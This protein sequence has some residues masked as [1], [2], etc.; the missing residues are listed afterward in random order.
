[1]KAILFFVFTLSL[2]CSTE[3]LVQRTTRLYPIADSILRN[4]YPNN[5]YGTVVTSPV[6]Q[7]WGADDNN[8]T[9]DF[10]ELV[11]MFNINSTF[12]PGAIIT[13]KIYYPQLNRVQA[14]V[15]SEVVF[16]A[17]EIYTNWTET[18]VTYNNRP[19]LRQSITTSH[20]DGDIDN[21]II[22]SSSAVIAAQ[23]R[24]DKAVAFLASSFD[25]QLPINMR[26]AALTNQW[27]EP[28]RPYMDVVYWS[29]N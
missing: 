21:V 8:P 10:Y 11:T 18:T 14:E 24:G 2:L 15:I 28:V 5:N 3:A 17:W 20:A 22:P 27:N 16:D 7:D 13:A 9:G 1:M 12:I 19:A 29:A 26:E 25:H 6:F 23:N 4:V